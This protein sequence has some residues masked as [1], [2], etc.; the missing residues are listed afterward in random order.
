MGKISEK[1][2]IFSQYSAEDYDWGVNAFS[3]IFNSLTLDRNEKKKILRRKN[4]CVKSII[5]RQYSAGDHI[6]AVNA[7]SVDYNNLSFDKKE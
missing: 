6:W 2:I 3:V 5:F 4:L 7:F 1:S